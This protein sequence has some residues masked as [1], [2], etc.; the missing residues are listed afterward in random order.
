MQVAWWKRSTVESEIIFLEKGTD[1]SE[2]MRGSEW[3]AAFVP[4]DA[5]TR[6]LVLR[7]GMGIWIT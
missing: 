6:A 3:E 5:L 7:I 1:G 2:W 4:L